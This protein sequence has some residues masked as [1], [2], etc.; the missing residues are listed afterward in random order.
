MSKIRI[1][2]CASCGAT[3]INSTN[4]FLRVP[5][6]RNRRE[7]WLKAASLENDYVPNIAYLCEDHFENVS[8][9]YP[10][11]CILSDL[12]RVEST[13][14]PGQVYSTAPEAPKHATPIDVLSY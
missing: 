3:D 13:L 6:D 1:K 9:R 7:E 8:S 14:S 11:T 5:N 12:D 2:R 10:K 4:I